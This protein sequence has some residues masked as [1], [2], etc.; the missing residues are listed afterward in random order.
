MKRFIKSSQTAEGVNRIE[1]DFYGVDL[2]EEIEAR[3]NPKRVFKNAAVVIRDIKAYLEGKGLKVL[4]TSRSNH[5]N[6]DSTY[7][8]VDVKIKNPAGKLGYLYFRISDHDENPNNEESRRNYHD[9]ITRGYENVGDDVDVAE[10]WN[11]T[12]IAVTGKRYDNY[13]R[14]MNYAKR[15]IDEVLKKEGLL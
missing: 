9:R 12:S 15:V 10:L 7:Y 2:E 11:Y 3:S 5:S 4:K 1:I 14:A 6:S 13:D 8:D